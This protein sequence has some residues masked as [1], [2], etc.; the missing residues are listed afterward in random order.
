MTFRKHRWLHN[1]KVSY[2]SYVF[3]YCH[4]PT[5]VCHDANLFIP[6]KNNEIIIS[7]YLFKKSVT[8]VEEKWSFWVYTY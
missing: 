4:I 7:M 2:L 8:T 5:L 6:V 1:L 3:Y